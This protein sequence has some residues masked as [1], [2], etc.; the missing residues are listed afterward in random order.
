MQRREAGL[1]GRSPLLLA[2]ALLMAGF[3][4]L[5]WLGIIASN[6]DVYIRVVSGWLFFP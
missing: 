5:V 6:P 3:A 4:G 1:P 2:G